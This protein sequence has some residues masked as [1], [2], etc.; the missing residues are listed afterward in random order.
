[1][2]DGKQH[3]DEVYSSKAAD[4]VSW[5]QN[6]PRTSVRLVELAGHGRPD[7][8]VIDVGGGTST[9]VDALLE[10]SH[11]VTVLDVSS[12]ALD[13]AVRR[14]GPRGDQVSWVQADLL[15][16][17]PERTF[18]VWH[19]RAVFHFLTDADGLAGYV[20]LVSRAIAPHGALVLG[21]FAL[22]GPSTCSGLPTARYDAEALAAHFA[23][24]F[25]L[26]HDEREL[27]RTPAGATQA[28][29][30]VVLRHA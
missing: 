1:M 7:A 22:D 5:F 13:A 6:T 16:W 17:R 25:V 9:L 29:T 26:E 30:W 15:D 10:T 19:D 28:F 18:D 12:V 3:W 8:S 20:D 2:E 11:D 27:H 24:A 21:V 4:E 23:G 14:L